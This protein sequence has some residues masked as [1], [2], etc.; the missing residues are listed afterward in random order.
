MIII[1][2]ASWL[3]LLGLVLALAGCYGPSPGLDPVISF[4]FPDGTTLPDLPSGT[5]LHVKGDATTADSSGNPITSYQWTQT[6][7]N[8][9]T[10]SSTTTLETTWLA[11]TLKATDKPLNVT[12]ILTVKSL[13]GG[14]AVKPL[15]LIIVPPSSASITLDLTAM[16][17]ENPQ[18]IDLPLIEVNTPLQMQGAATAV[19][20]VNNPIITYAWSANP[21]TAATI[22]NAAGM[23]NATITPTATGPLTVTLTV[24][25][26]SGQTVQKSLTLLVKP[27]GNVAAM[28]PAFVWDFKDMNVNGAIQLPN[29]VSGTSMSLLGTPKPLDPT[30]S[31]AS[32]QWAQTTD[33]PRNLLGTFSAVNA[34]P[35][36]WRAPM[37]PVTQSPE[38]ITLTLTMTTA[39]GNVSSMPLTVQVLPPGMNP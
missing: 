32:Y 5:V 28:N 16:N 26:L 31:I 17:A 6:P 27:T 38:T 11:P 15:N 4:T 25:L 10:F 1:R 9:G 39:K 14:K 36:S 8:A 12:L 33:D 19:D 35:A 2:N 23:F 7:A 22:N 29:I 37:I 34:F 3:F 18:A 20:P 30:D 13:K 21:S 24:T